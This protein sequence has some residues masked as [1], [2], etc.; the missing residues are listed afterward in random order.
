VSQGVPLGF[1]AW[2]HESFGAGS[3]VSLKPA[4]LFS[5]LQKGLGLLE[6]SARRHRAEIRAILERDFQ[7]DREV[8]ILRSR[9]DDQTE[10]V[11]AGVWGAHP[12]RV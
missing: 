12:S 3:S 4:P 8:E 9:C 5:C 11:C 6:S 2:M 10:A 7:K 1:V